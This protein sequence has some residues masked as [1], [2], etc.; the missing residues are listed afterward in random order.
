MKKELFDDFE[1]EI[2]IFL[3]WNILNWLIIFFKDL[4]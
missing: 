2:F 4:F 3:H 1:Q